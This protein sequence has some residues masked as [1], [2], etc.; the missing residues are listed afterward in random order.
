MN[1]QT[2]RTTAK[3]KKSKLKIALTVIASLML[4]AGIGVLMFP[5]AN[6]FFNDLK[7]A[8]D[9]DHFEETRCD[10]TVVD[11][12]KTY[13]PELYEAFRQ[14][15]ENLYKTGQSDLKDP[16]SYEKSDFDLTKY[17]IENNMIGYLK[18]PKMDLQISVRLGAS[19]NNMNYGAV[20]LSKTSMPI[21]GNNT[22]CVIA[23]HRG[24]DVKKMFRYI[25]KLEAGDDVYLTNSWETLHYKVSE[26]T[27]ILP[28]DIKKVL[29]QKNRDMLTLFT[30]TPYRIN[31]HR[32]V[33][34]CDR[35]V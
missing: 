2:D 10:E 32:Y 22:N 8:A 18:I 16:F 14:Y 33:V 9:I 11:P 29:I 25:D 12:H 34:Y 19:R 26:I 13:L 28:N 23:A 3:P 31:S 24:W 7:T 15:N 30:C 17:G 1:R 21:G 6:D 35:V 4:L 5:Y 27:K 20:H